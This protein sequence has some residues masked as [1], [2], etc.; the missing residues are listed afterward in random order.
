MSPL[1]NDEGQ[2]IGGIAVLWDMSDS[3]RSE[4]LIERLVFNDT[5]TGL[6][7]RT[8]F[9]DR[10]R[11]VLAGATR[12]AANPIVA[13]V[14]LDRFRA[15]NEAI[16][17]AAGDR[18]LQAV[19]ARLQGSMRAEDTVG[20]WG[21]DEF[22]VLLPGAS[23]DIDSFAVASRLAHCFSAPWLIDGYELWLTASIGLA[24][25]PTTGPTPR[26]CSTTPRRPCTTP[27]NAAA[28]ASDSTRRP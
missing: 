1:R 12:A 5:I 25:I 16:G 20:R 10:L 13:L 3:L 23:A 22:A 4:E 27:R 28:T 21:G 15:V 11:Q 8:L 9:R 6:P 19:G 24:V 18:L 2:T 17:H 26:R 14:N 7:N